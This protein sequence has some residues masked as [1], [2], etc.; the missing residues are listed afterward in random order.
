[1]PHRLYRLNKGK[2]K[3]KESIC[4]IHTNFKT[5]LMKPGL[6]KMKKK[7]RDM[8]NWNT[9]FPTGFKRKSTCFVICTKFTNQFR[10]VS[11]F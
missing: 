4:P 9:G 8:E 11:S 7:K 6:K 3:S 2:G 10:L 5:C 1:M